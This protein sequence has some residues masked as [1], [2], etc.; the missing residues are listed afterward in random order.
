VQKLEKWLG[1]P[2]VP[3]VA[4]TGEG[5]KELISRLPE[6]CSPKVHK[7]SRDERW[8]DIGKIVGEVQ[9]LAHRHHTFLERLQ[10]LSVKP[11]TGLPIAALVAYLAFKVIRFIGEG[12]I[13]YVFEPIFE[14]FTPFLMK[15]SVLL[16]GS[17]FLHDILIGK[18][19]EGQID[20]VQSFGLLTTGLFVPLGMVLPY[21]GSFYLVLSALEDFGYLTRLAVLVDN[22]FHR[23]GLH[24]FAIIPMLLGLGCN[25][26][27]VMATR[28]LESQRER[29]IAATLITIGVPCAALQAMIIG[30]LGKH[31]GGPV[32]VVY[33]TLFIVWLVLGFVLNRLLPGFSPTL[34]IEMPPYRIPPWRALVKKVWM[35]ILMF[36]KEAV[37]IVLL[38]VLI[39]NILYTVGIFDFIAN[40]TAPVIT[41][42][43]GL[44]KEAITAL[45]I[46]F[47]RKDVAV[48]MFVPLNL[49][50]KQSIVGCTVLSMFFP[51]IATFIILI[52]EI[53]WKDM[54]KA[55]GIMIMAAILVGSL[56]N[57]LL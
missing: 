7:H 36:L 56:L 12:L 3:T 29:F 52:R 21:I 27:G 55:T 22:I 47:L 24:G 28:I 6:A 20:F 34:L 53:G 41:G 43:L 50:V 16:G 10:D 57:F 26:P 13:G 39:V 49:T 8:E 4:V 33:G 11:K 17:G 32:A 44:P 51:C 23:L 19:I 37:P 54:L 5:L 2:V 40:F 15:L 18:L 48:G 25:V 46:G 14:F 1:V 31:G 35:R 45:V 30:L 38:G 42:L 9:T